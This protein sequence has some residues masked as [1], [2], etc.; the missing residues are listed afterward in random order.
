M[1]T[2][3]PWGKSQSSDK[4][5]PGIVWY[6][7]ASHGGFHL[8]K[9]RIEQMPEPYR[10]FKPFAGE[11]WYEEDCDWAIVCLCFTKEWTEWCGGN[12]E[13]HL[14]QALRTLEAYQEYFKF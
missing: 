5:A 12:I 8:S 4:V 2:N 6:T 13:L 11:G 3:T 10:S 7:T 14:A 9:K 1:A